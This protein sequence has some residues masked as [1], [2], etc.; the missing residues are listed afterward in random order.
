MN[1]YYF[2]IRTAS[3]GHVGI[4][5]QAASWPDAEVKLRKRYP[6]CTILECQQR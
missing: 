3:G 5:I 6:G 2:S 1:Q 4:T